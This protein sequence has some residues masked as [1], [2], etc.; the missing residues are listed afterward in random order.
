[1]LKFAIPVCM[2]PAQ[3]QRKSFTVVV[4]V[5][6]KLLAIDRLA[7]LIRATWV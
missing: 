7:A 5:S 1:M 6:V 2:Y 3:P 4:S